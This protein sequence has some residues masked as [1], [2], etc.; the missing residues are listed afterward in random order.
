MIVE[1]RCEKKACKCSDFGYWRLLTC[2]GVQYRNRFN[3]SVAWEVLGFR[4]LRWFTMATSIASSLGASPCYSLQ[5][6][7]QLI[8]SSHSCLSRVR[9][10]SHTNSFP[11]SF[12]FQKASSLRNEAANKLQKS[13][14][15]IRPIVCRASTGE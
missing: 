5:L 9:G 3:D 12:H 8:P 13:S 2:I 6:L 7:K 10:S 1:I 14:G 15:A 11:H 4:V